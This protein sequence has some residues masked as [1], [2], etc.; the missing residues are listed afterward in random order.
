MKNRG[1]TEFFAAKANSSNLA[2]SFEKLG[3]TPIF[4]AAKNSVRPLFFLASRAVA[5]DY[6]MTVETPNEPL[7]AI[8]P[9]SEALRA[10]PRGRLGMR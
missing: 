2:S 5:A 4:F 7:G 1:R 9:E 8:R 6:V 10:L 3:S